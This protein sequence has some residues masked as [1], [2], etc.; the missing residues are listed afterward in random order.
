MSVLKSIARGYN[1]LLSA[2][3][4]IAGFILIALFVLICVQVFARLLP[5]TA[6][7]WTTDLATYCLIILGFIGM[8]F[9]LRKGA[10]VAIDILVEVLPV[11]VGQVIGV[12]TCVIGA[13]TTIY[14]AFAA[15]DVTMSQFERGVYIT[16]SMGNV[17]K[18]ILLA[19]IPFGLSMTFIEFIVLI[20]KHFLG[21]IRPGDLEVEKE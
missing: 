12:I 20:R 2:T 13:V 14:V 19:F 6:V 1:K 11:R 17:P 5:I 7:L 15:I 8:A 18:W 16:A 10:H 4:V 3:N 9:V 21:V